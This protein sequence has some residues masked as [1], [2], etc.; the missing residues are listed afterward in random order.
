MDFQ[1]PGCSILIVEDEILIALDIAD[2]FKRAG[3][4]TVT[5]HSLKEALRLVEEDNWSAAVLDHLLGD[6]ESS[7]LCKRL[8]ERD[9]PFV[10]YTGRDPIDG[11]CNSGIYVSKPADTETLVSLVR[12]AIQ[13]GLT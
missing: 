12:Q 3:A 1:L 13:D 2:T 5:T 6:T 4:R 11:D 9:I 8:K 10:L 7:P